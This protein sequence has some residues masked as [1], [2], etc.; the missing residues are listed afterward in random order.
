[1]LSGGPS[2]EL[3]A[4]VGPRALAYAAGACGAVEQPATHKPTSAAATR[5]R[6][7]AQHSA[8]AARLHP[9][10]PIHTPAAGNSLC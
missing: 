9:T 4:M 6:R 2:I 5:T 7:N 10:V 8:P 3:N 1:M